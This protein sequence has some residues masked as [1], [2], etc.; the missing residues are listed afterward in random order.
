[1]PSI[2]FSL[3]ADQGRQ[4]YQ[5]WIEEGVEARR[6]DFLDRLAD[7]AKHAWLKVQPHGAQYALSTAWADLRA[8]NVRTMLH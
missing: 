3:P 1:M 2:C 5:L 6:M 7:A 8:F 4:F